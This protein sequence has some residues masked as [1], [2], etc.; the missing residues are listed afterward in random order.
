M[1]Q[2]RY[3]DAVVLYQRAYEL[4]N[5]PALLY[6]QARASQAL[7][8]PVAALDLIE[9]FEAEASPA[10]KA[11]VPDLAGLEAD[12]RSRTSSLT[13]T[14][15]VPGA[16]LLLRGVVLGKA[17]FAA[18]IRTTAGHATIVVRAESYDAFEREI[19]LPSNGALTVDATLRL[20]DRRGFLLVKSVPGAR[21]AFDGEAKGDAPV[22]VAALEGVHELRVEADG[23]D[24]KVSSVVIV[25]GAHKELS[26]DLAKKPSILAKWWFWTAIGVVV[27]GGVTT[28]V[29]VTSEKKAEPGSIS[30]GVVSGPLKVAF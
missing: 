9:R 19:D 5:D 15:N 20:K 11:R 4:S 18:P 6:N 2:D 10:L 25:T 21:V 29:V 8:D 28:Y 7:G 17:P 30:P 27:A 1:D 13:V 12:L 22:E 16:E 23:Y 3:A 26:V 14:C 24:P